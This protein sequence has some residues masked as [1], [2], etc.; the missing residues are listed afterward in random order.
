MS[1]VKPLPYAEFT[2]ESLG[3]KR[4]VRQDRHQIGNMDDILT[5]CILVSTSGSSVL[6]RRTLIATL[7]SFDSCLQIPFHTSANPPWA[8]GYFPSRLIFPV[9]S[10]KDP[11]VIV[12]IPAEGRW[13]QHPLREKQ[14]RTHILLLVG[15]LVGTD[16]LYHPPG[17]DARK[18]T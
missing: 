3:Q 15:E 12:F 16:R 14:G 17:T 8:Q 7:Y 11:L 18:R 9:R 10:S 4:V 6:D 1:I 5:L 13:H 2:T